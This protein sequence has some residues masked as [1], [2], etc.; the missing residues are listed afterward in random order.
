MATA[1]CFEERNV[2]KHLKFT[3]KRFTWKFELEKTQFTIDLFISRVSGKKKILVN[4]DIKVET[5]NPMPLGSSFPLRYGIHKLQ[6]ICIGDNSYDLRIDG[7]SFIGLLKKSEARRTKRMNEAGI[8]QSSPGFSGVDLE[9]LDS[10]QG[11]SSYK[12]Q[13]GTSWQSFATPIKPKSDVWEDYSSDK[14]SHTENYELPYGLV[15]AYPDD[16]ATESTTKPRTVSFQ[17]SPPKNT[18][19]HKLK[20]VIETEEISAPKSIYPTLVD[21]SNSVTSGQSNIHSDPYTIPAVKPS[22]IPVPTDPF[23]K[24]T[25]LF[26]FEESKPKIAVNKAEAV[27][28]TVPFP[29]TPASVTEVRVDPFA[30]SNQENLPPRSE[31]SKPDLISQVV[32]LDNLQLGDRYSPA[33]MKK[34]QEATKPPTI[35]NSA[36]IPM[37]QFSTANTATPMS[38]NP[39]SMMA[40]NQ[41]MT[42]MILARSMQ[43]F[44]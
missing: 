8:S 7:L 24:Q 36:N 25:N 33:V 31:N 16:A 6:V 14:P 12:A 18:S 5:S 38:S 19:H 29:P 26:G 42:N 30:S 10:G 20:S 11:D 21:I 17:D 15:P 4:G 40:F 13:F 41:F 39:I 2:G 28:S 23:P 1:L 34:Y 27:P 37:N 44:T 43:K 32:D 35:S 3:K 9:E 22:Q